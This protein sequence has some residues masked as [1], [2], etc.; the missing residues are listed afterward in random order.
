MVDG[1]KIRDLR[2]QAYLTQ[3]ELGKLVG[4]DQ[5]MIGFIEREIKRPSIELL[6]RIA[7]YFGVAMDDLRKKTEV[8]L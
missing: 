6:A 8:D 3:T 5:S 7:D 1:S 2:E 4:A